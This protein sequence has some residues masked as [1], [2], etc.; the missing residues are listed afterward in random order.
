MVP[1]LAP[2][3][4]ALALPG[5]NRRPWL[6]AVHPTRCPRA[7][8]STREGA[9]G[10]VQ[11]GSHTWRKPQ[12][13]GA[14]PV[15]SADPA[16]ATTDGD[17][18]AYCLPPPQNRARRSSRIVPG[19]TRLVGPQRTLWICVVVLAGACAARAVWPAI[20]PNPVTRI[21]AMVPARVGTK[22]SPSSI[23]R[24]AV[25]PCRSST[26]SVTLPPAGSCADSSEMDG[27]EDPDGSTTLANPP[28]PLTRGPAL[29]AK[30]VNRCP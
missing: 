16:M 11:S 22:R 28:G 3:R 8:P 25:G 29:R 9:K 5:G 10:S 15:G 1:D 12:Q 19:G 26:S 6:R 20:A 30:G 27:R 13:N 7:G 24:G 14:A 21:H 18:L 4:A 2:D 23:F 17:H